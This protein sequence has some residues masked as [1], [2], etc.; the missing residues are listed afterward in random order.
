MSKLLPLTLSLALLTF[1]SVSQAEMKGGP[2][3]WTGSATKYEVVSHP[4][5]INP[6]EVFTLTITSTQDLDATLKDDDGRVLQQCQR[7]V[8]VLRYVNPE[9]GYLQHLT[10]FLINPGQKTAYYSVEAR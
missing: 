3:E 8:C 5:L 1:S 9:K 2:Q 10:L 6:R 7:T 4:L